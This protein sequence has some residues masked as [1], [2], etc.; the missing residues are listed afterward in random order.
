MLYSYI[1]SVTVI[2]KLKYL[3]RFLIVMHR[4][5]SLTPSEAC[6]SAGAEMKVVATFVPVSSSTSEFLI[7]WSVIR[8]MWPFLVCHIQGKGVTQNISDVYWTSRQSPFSPIWLMV[9][10]RSCT[11]SIEVHFEARF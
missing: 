8:L 5:G 7:S 4:K 1:L 9:C 3:L 10:Y 6:G 11:V 2:S